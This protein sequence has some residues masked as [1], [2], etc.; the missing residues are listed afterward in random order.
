MNFFVQILNKQYEI[1]PTHFLTDDT[2]TEIWSKIYLD[3]QVIELNTH[4]SMQYIMS[5][6]VNCITEVAAFENQQIGVE[7][8]KKAVK[9]QVRRVL[10][11]LKKEVLA[12]A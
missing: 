10:R 7:L 3:E 12:Y 8:D 11:N 6:L 4:A 2:N 9:L 5:E 1:Y